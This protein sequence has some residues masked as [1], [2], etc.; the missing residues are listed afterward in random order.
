MG[1]FRRG[2]DLSSDID[3]VFWHQFVLKSL[4]TMVSL[5]SMSPSSYVSRSETS[6]EATSQRTTGILNQVKLALCEAGV[7]SEETIMAQ[8]LLSNSWTDKL[9]NLRRRSN[10]DR[11]CISSA[12][13]C[14][15]QL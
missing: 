10:E 15:P 5:T 12:G 8:G 6:S 14:I 4:P 9:I 11:L 7:I 2:E 3:I 13:P 1:S